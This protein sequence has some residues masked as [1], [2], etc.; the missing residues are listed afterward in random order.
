MTNEEKLNEVQRL[1]EAEVNK[2][3]DVRFGGVDVVGYKSGRDF[4]ASQT[5]T[6]SETDNRF[7][8]LDT[9]GSAGNLK[10]ALTKMISDPEAAR[11][12]GNEEALIDALDRQAEGEVVAFRD[13]NPTYYRSNE[14]WVAMVR[15][16]AFN[17][18]G[19]RDV[20]DADPDEC[21]R[22]LLRNGH[23]VEP[24]L[25]A[26]FKTLFNA[27]SL[28][29]SPDAPR[30]LTLQ[31]Q[32]AVMLLAST[33]PEAAIGKYLQYRLPEGVIE[34]WS[35]LDDI[36]DPAYAHVV[37]EAAWFVWENSRP[38]YSPT[39]ERR[40]FMKSYVAGRVPTL[41][42]LDAAWVA[43]QSE[44]KDVTRQ[45]VLSQLN[46]STQPTE[47]NIDD[48]SDDE[49]ANLYNSTR[50]HISRNKPRRVGMLI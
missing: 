24:N 50:R 30:P 33:N 25:T 44:E 16:M 10:A 34:D 47:Q 8:P 36:A 9:R 26:I 21:Y 46:P 14:N 3:A 13:K 7:A 4:A 29:V 35:E 18:L 23:F 39:S 37:G 11:E 41:R 19:R 28:D 49:V 15:C 17:F 40:D 48:L 38:G 32:R 31:Q 45:S 2:W 20:E 43:R 22:E 12:S 42:L 6:D 27:G 5:G 1:G